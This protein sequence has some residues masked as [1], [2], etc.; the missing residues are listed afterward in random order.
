MA[1]NLQA[2]HNA[3]QRTQNLALDRLNASANTFANAAANGG[4]EARKEGDA[5]AR[6]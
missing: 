6:S 4:N 3:T 1:V 2:D 5:A